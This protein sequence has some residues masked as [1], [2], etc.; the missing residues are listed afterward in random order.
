MSVLTLIQAGGAGSRLGILGEKRAKSAAQM[1]LT[2][3][4]KAR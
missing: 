3:C 4:R 2:I 1:K